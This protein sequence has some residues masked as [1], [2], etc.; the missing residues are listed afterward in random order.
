MAKRYGKRPTHI[1][2][3]PISGEFYRP[4]CGRCDQLPWNACACSALLPETAPEESP[5]AELDERLQM[6][7]WKEAA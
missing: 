1:Q 2:A 7:L 4:S 3:A 6:L 5:T